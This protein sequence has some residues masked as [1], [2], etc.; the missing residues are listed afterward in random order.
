[1]TAFLLG[2]CAMAS[3]VIAMFLWKFYR[4]TSD[5][6]FALFALAF[7]S[8]S[9]H[10][11]GLGIVQPTEETRHYFFLLRLL[12]FCLIIAGIV[13]KNRGTPTSGERQR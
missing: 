1:M 10:W 8:L 4:R 2:A 9:A 7:A 13:A 11:I 5:R 12:A 3:A 6:L